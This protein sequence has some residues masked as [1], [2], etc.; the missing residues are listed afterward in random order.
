MTPGK[1]QRWSELSTRQQSGIGVA[2]LV[3]L[4]LLIAALR[5]LR[6]RP[7]DEINGSKRM[8]FAISF[9][10][11]IGPLAYFRFGRKR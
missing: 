3:E 1:K 8:W 11:I 5:D 6:R 4:V 7:A 2:G 10:N 9:V